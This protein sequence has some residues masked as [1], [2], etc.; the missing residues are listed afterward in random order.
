MKRS[1]FEVNDYKLYAEDGNAYSKLQETRTRFG[2]LLG[3]EKF[4]FNVACLSLSICPICSVE[5]KMSSD[6]GL[7]NVI[8]HL[9]RAHKDDVGS[10]VISRWG[11][12]KTNVRLN[13][14]SFTEEEKDTQIH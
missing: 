1:L 2:N 10:K 12:M 14:L 5:Q 8:A 4:Q 7:S 9:K 6:G 13:I 11:L 3:A